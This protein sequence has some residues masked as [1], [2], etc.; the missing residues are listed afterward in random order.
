MHKSS[1]FGQEELH[2]DLQRLDSDL[3]GMY[4]LTPNTKEDIEF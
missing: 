3:D 2:G 1:T 4:I